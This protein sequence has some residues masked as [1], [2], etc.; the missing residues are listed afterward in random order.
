MYQRENFEYYIKPELDDGEMSASLETFLK[1]SV[2]SSNYDS[3]FL[4]DFERII[5][6]SSDIINEVLDSTHF[7]KSNNKITQHNLRLSVLLTILDNITLSYI[8]EDKVAKVNSL[9]DAD[10]KQ[11]RKYL[12]Y[13]EKEKDAGVLS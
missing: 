1:G 3:L 11:D 8:T 4:E 10:L 12:K 5:E 2:Q 9:K 7:F 6:H 13:L